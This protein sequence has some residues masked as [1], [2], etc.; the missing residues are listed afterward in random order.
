ME[1]IKADGLVEERLADEIGVS[2][3]PIREADRKRV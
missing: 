3:T 2:R 1:L